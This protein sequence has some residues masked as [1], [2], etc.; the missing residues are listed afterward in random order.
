MEKYSS[1]PAPDVQAMCCVLHAQKCCLVNTFLVQRCASAVIFIGFVK[2]YTTAFQTNPCHT[3]LVYDAVHSPFPSHLLHLSLLSAPTCSPPLCPYLLPSSLP[4]LALLLPAP[5][6]SP[7]LCPYLL[8]PPCLSAPTCS[9]PLCPYLLPPPSSLPLL[10][11]LPPLCPYLLPPL[12]PYLLPSLPPSSNQLCINTAIVYM[13][14]F[15]TVHSFRSFNRA[16]S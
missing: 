2:Y 11:P 3:T 9:P 1:F 5:T 8:P 14:R 12:C 13:H 7:P 6:C 4:L 16:V 10:A 15:Y